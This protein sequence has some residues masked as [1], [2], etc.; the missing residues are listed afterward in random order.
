MKTTV[1]CIATTRLSLGRAEIRATDGDGPLRRQQ[2]RERARKAYVAHEVAYQD[3][4]LTA[5]DRTLIPNAKN[6]ELKA[7]LVKA[8]PAFEAQLARARELQAELKRNGA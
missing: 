1:A 2:S 4:V 8:R 7:L 6:P 3:S 5:L